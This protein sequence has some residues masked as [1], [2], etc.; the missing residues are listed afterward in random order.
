MGSVFIGLSFLLFLTRVQKSI[1]GNMTSGKIQLVFNTYSFRSPFPSLAP[2]SSPQILTHSREI[3]ESHVFS[4]FTREGELTAVCL[5]ISPHWPSVCY[6]Q[7][8]GHAQTRFCVQSWLGRDMFWCQSVPQQYPFAWKAPIWSSSKE[9]GNRNF[10]FD[11][12]KTNTLGLNEHNMF[13]YVTEKPTA[14]LESSLDPNS[15]LCLKDLV[16]LNSWLTALRG[17]LSFNINSLQPGG[18]QL[19][20]TGSRS[21]GSVQKWRILLTAKAGINS[22]WFPLV[23]MGTSVLVPWLYSK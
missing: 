18:C 20:L 12:Q 19:S 2:F 6:S 17:G 11:K 3:Q 1:N 8:V 10:S 13:P 7:V 16:P 14:T 9:G 15:K 4:V 23:P 5:V 21:C 22:D